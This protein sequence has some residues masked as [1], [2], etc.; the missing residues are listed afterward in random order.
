MSEFRNCFNPI[1]IHRRC[2]NFRFRPDRRFRHN[3]PIHPASARS[4][5]IWSRCMG[6]IKAGISLTSVKFISESRNTRTYKL[7]E[8]KGTTGMENQKRTLHRTQHSSGK[9]MRS[10]SL[11]QSI[12]W[13]SIDIYERKLRTSCF[14]R[15]SFLWCSFRPSHDV[16]IRLAC[17]RALVNNV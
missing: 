17:K 3:A 7:Y 8:I 14:L 16:Q 5:K 4:I 9:S 10:L 15:R 13:E 12:R 2:G 11:S 6:E 1:I